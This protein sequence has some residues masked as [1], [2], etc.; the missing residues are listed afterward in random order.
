MPS[1]QLMQTF[2]EVILRLGVLTE[3]EIRDLGRLLSKLTDD[4]PMFPEDAKSV[5]T[6]GA[7]RLLAESCARFPDVPA[8]WHEALGR[9]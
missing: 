7:W 6:H 2:G 1:P 3:A 4:G 8:D 5:T 9:G